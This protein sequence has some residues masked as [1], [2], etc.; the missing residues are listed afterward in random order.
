MKKFHKMVAPPPHTAFMKSL[1]RTLTV[2]LSTYIVLN[3][4]YEIRLTAPQFA[5]K[6]HKR[7]GGSTEFHNHISYSDIH[8][9]QKYGQISE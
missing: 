6:F 5:K 3:K 1:F 8:M 4:G 7:A 2:F 9:Y